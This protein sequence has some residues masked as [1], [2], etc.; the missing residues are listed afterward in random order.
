MMLI[1]AFVAI[2]FA[3]HRGI[4]KKGNQPPSSTKLL[5]APGWKSGVTMSVVPMAL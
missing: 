1:R 3:K 5:L 2:S 4:L